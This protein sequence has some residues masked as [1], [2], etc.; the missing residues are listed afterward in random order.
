MTSGT[1]FSSKTRTA[2]WPPG[3][4]PGPLGGCWHTEY[5]PDR[6]ANIALEIKY[7]LK[8]IQKHY[9]RMGPCCVKWIVKQNCKRQI[10]QGEHPSFRTVLIPAHKLSAATGPD[11]R[12]Y[13]LHVSGQ[14]R[15]NGVPV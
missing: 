8:L 6:F 12:C 14:V 15:L 10:E 9:N 2:C 5:R 3:A 4:W 13:T 7:E 1:I 11:L